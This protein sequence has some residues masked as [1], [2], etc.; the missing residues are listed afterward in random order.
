[1]KQLTL[2]FLGAFAALLDDEPLSNFRSA[3]VQG[4]LIDDWRW[5]DNAARDLLHLAET[6]DEDGLREGF[7]TAVPV[8]TVLERNEAT[9]SL[10]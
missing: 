7:L 6:I 1:M 10:S 5:A 3:K 9:A 4:L 2:S 8:R